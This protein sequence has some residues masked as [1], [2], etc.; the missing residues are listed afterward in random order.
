[1]KSTVS[2]R[3][4]VKTSVAVATAATVG[5]PMVSA[6]DTVGF[7]KD[8]SW[9]KGVCRFCGV[10]CGLMV[11]TRDGQVSVVKGDPDNDV[12]RGLLCAKGFANANILYG[13][14]RL[15]KPLLRM[16]DDRFDKQGEFT[17]VSWER[18]FD[19][20]ER[21]FKRV[22]GEL[23]PTGVGIMGSG[24][25]TI[26]E[27][28]ASVKLTK[29]GST[30]IVATN[31]TVV[32]ASQITCKVNMNGAARGLWNVVVT[33]PDGQSGTLSNGLAAQT[34]AWLPTVFKNG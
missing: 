4:F 27:G 16:K 8:I 9:E 12:N 13:A 5:V 28:Y 30:D 19:E 24:Q 2:R 3:D 32:S 26:P 15:H 25:Y 31:V 21:Q 23:G 29:A 33:N 6:K 22:F 34:C 18:A 1:M 7:D 14:D 11:G 20:M 10:G 17:E